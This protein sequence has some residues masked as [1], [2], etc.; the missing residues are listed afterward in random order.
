VAEKVPRTKV[1]RRNGDGGQAG[2][3]GAFDHEQTRRGVG[4]VRGYIPLGVPRGTSTL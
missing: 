3:G 1:R 2:R 4:G